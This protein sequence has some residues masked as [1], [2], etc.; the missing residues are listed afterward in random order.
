MFAVAK[1][2]FATGKGQYIGWSVHAE[3]RVVEWIPGYAAGGE[4]EDRGEGLREGGSGGI[5]EKHAE[6]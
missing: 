4:M 3:S 5:F 1:F 2:N 6:F